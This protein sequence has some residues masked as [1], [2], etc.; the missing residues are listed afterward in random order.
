MSMVPGDTAFTLTGASSSARPRVNDFKSAVYC[1]DNSSS[2]SRTNAKVARHQRKRTA[3]ADFGRP[4]DTPGSPELAFHGRA[5]IIH[6]NGLERPRAQLRSR[7]D[8][9]VDRPAFAEKIRDAFVAGDI[10]GMP[11]APILS[12]A[13]FRRS[14]LRDATT[15]SAPSRLAKFCSRKTDAG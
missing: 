10:G 4:R 15:T 9:M 2:G 1:T 7:H 11:V 6:G 13:A 12:A 5:N 3:G 8:D 14:A